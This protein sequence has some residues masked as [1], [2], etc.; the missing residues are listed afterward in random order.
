MRA[1]SSFPYYFPIDFVNSAFKKAQESNIRVPCPKLVLTLG[2]IEYTFDENDLI[3]FTHKENDL[4]HITNA[5]LR[6]ADKSLTD[7]DLKSYTAVLSHG[8]K[9]SAGNKYSACAPQVVRSMDLSS[10]QGQLFCYLHCIG[11][12]DLLQEDKAS[13]KYNHHWSSTKTVKTLISEVASGTP[14]E[15][16]LEEELDVSGS[17]QNF[18]GD[19]SVGMAQFLIID[20]RE[21]TKIRFKLKKVGSPTGNVT[22]HIADADTETDLA[23]KIL[24]DASA[25]STSATWYEVTLTTPV[26]TDPAHR[27]I[28]YVD[29]F[30]GNESNYIAGM[31]YPGDYRAGE[32]F[33]NILD[34]AENIFEQFPDK[35]CCYGYSYTFAGIEVYDHCTELE[36][37]FDSEDSLIDSYTP[38]DSFYISKNEDKLSVII[39]LLYHTGCRYR[40]ENDGKMHIFVPVTSGTTYDAEY[41]L[42]SGHPLLAKA[43]RKALVSPNKVIINTP[44]GAPVAYSGEATTSDYASLPDNQK[45]TEFYTMNLISDAQGNAI[46]AARISRMEMAAQQ[47]SATVPINCGAELYDYVKCTDSREGNTKI[48]N[49]GNLE[50][51]YNSG[52]SGKASYNMNFSFGGVALQ[53]VPGFRPSSIENP[54]ALRRASALKA[55]ILYANPDDAVLTWGDIKD[56]F[57]EITENQRQL[58]IMANLLEPEPGNTA[59]DLIDDALIGYSSQE[60]IQDIINRKLSSYHNYTAAPENR[61]DT[62]YQNHLS[63]SKIISV[64]VSLSSGTAERAYIKIGSSSPP[65][66]IIGSFYHSSG[67]NGVEAQSRTFIVPPGYYFEI[68]TSLGTPT[69]TYWVEWY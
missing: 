47:G 29:Y 24:S 3:A 53:S 18:D 16:E 22:F 23:S 2:A 68:E 33:A 50:V 10:Y 52:W 58:M 35:D 57:N 69:I 46:A 9:I 15:E 31:Y 25:I 17:W 40:F 12:P 59:E 32:W 21:V 64:Q 13:D 49:I 8:L 56:W 39:R 38:K 7:I 4:S 27:I 1:L 66:E 65:T 36:L 20:E 62:I 5:T 42:D 28:L 6:N 11:M 55:S 41:S 63:R 30:N 43:V 44:E 19:A 37:V 14:V 54:N 26:T 48:G 61:I 60:A 67:V 34:T 51:T 45:K